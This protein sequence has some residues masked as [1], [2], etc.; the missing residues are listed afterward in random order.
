MRVILV[1]VFILM[2]SAN[3]AFAAC[4]LGICIGKKKTDEEEKPRSRLATVI[5]GEK[6]DGATARARDWGDKSKNQDT[7][8]YHK[9]RFQLG[10]GAS[11]SPHQQAKRSSD[12]QNR[13]IEMEFNLN[14]YISFKS[15]WTTYRVAPISS[16]EDYQGD[17]KY[18][19]TSLRWYPKDQWRLQVG[20]GLGWAEIK[21]ERAN[22]EK[23]KDQVIVIQTGLF[24]E[25]SKGGVFL[26]GQITSFDGQN[27][28][29]NLGSTHYQIMAG[30][31]F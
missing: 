26:G 25:F 28:D 10:F 31:S 2:F 30:I 20:G 3:Q 12:G 29:I 11:V 1:L 24:R 21:Q 13:T 15:G 23:Q 14:G 8:R 4:A 18:L 19:I 16:S 22:P 9:F 7:A 17:Y 6:E 27:S 5:L